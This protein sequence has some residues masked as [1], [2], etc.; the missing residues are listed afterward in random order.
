[1]RALVG[2]HEKKRPA[3]MLHRTI[4]GFWVSHSSVNCTYE[5]RRRG[6]PQSDTKPV[7]KAGRTIALCQEGIEAGSIQ[8]FHYEILI[9]GRYS[10]IG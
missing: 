4:A 5:S 3:P 10:R 7:V 2:A 1:M 9:A 8:Q 6:C